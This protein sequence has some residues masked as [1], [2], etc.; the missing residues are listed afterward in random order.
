MV[1]SF[2]KSF[3][4]ALSGLRY[5]YK[6]ERNFRIECIVASIVIFIVFLFPMDTWKQVT[7]V[8]M[9]GW[10][11]SAELANT[12]VERMVDMLKPKLHPYVRVIKDL[13]AATVLLS[14]F[15]ALI[16]GI[17]IFLSYIM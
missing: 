9:V 8:V 12:I 3:R 1:R 4:C 16:V 11:L 14:S 15:V 13:M 7:L 17:L 2:L 5:A 10:V 6:H